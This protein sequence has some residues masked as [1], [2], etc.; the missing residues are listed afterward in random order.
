MKKL[1][2]V[3]A[4]FSALVASAEITITGVTARQRW[5]W[6]SLV[7]VDFTV[8]GKVGEAYAIDISATAA[9]GEKKLCATTFLTEPIARS[10]VK[11]RMVWDLGADYPNF[12]ADDLKVT[13]A[14]TPFSDKMP[15]YLVVDISSG[16]DSASY[17]V[18]YTTT[19]PVHTPGAEDPCKTTELWFK[20][21]K[22][23]TNHMGG[24]GGYAEHVCT[25]TNDFYLGVF[26]LTQAQAMNIVGEYCSYFTNGQDRLTRPCDT[27]LYTKV[28]N[29]LK[30]P[31][32]KD[33]T[34]DCISTRLKNRTGGL[35]FCLPTEWQWEYACRAGTNM[36]DERYPGMQCR[37]NEN[38]MPSKDYEWY[39]N[40]N[41]WSAEYGT[42][43]VDACAP[44]PWGFYG[45]IGNVWE[46]CANLDSQSL[47]IAGGTLVEPEGR[48]A[49]SVS[50]DNQRRR[51]LR[52]GCWRSSYDY[53][54][55]CTRTQLDYWNTAAAGYGK[56]T[57]GVRLC[58]TV[59]K[60]TV[61]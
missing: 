7:D 3:A 5:P 9:G 46:W 22:A 34:A 30:W 35:R 44:N 52:G 38:S 43:Y 16:K 57:S 28:W 6:N 51:V 36:A 14:A 41:M 15:L 59:G 42:S 37:N 2:M 13:V 20:R 61:E 23:G 45:M 31:D 25:L 21:V 40:Q 48:A 29:N 24:T 60:E 54:R 8:N 55:C 49:S 53:S 1:M 19:A 56:Y 32:I 11:T 18:R 4:A 12:K 17:P 27:I 50:S 58:L 47:V 26:E 39:S 33:I 10:G